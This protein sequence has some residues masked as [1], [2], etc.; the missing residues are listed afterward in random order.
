MLPTFVEVDV[1]DQGKQTL[2]NSLKRF[3][4]SGNVVPSQQNLI[5]KIP[6]ATATNPGV[7]LPIP[8]EGPQDAHTELHSITGAQGLNLFGMGTISSVGAVVTG[9]GT[10]FLSQVAVGD[11]ILE[12]AG[13]SKTVLSITSDTVLNTTANFAPALSNVNFVV[14][15][16]I[17]ADVRDRMTVTIHDV[18]YN[19]LLM[20][21]PVPCNH[22]FGDN[23]KPSMLCERIFLQKNHV[24]RYQFFNNSTSGAGSMG[25]TMEGRKWQIEA[26]ENYPEVDKLM[27]SF[28]ARETFLSPYWLTLETSPGTTKTTIPAGGNINQF[29]RNT[30]SNWLFLFFAY[31]HG[32]STGAAGETTE[33]FSFELFDKETDTP[34]QRMPATLNT[35]LGTAQNPYRFPTPIIMKPRSQLRV[36]FTNLITDQATDVFMTLGGVALLDAS[37]G[38]ADPAIMNEARR[39]YDATSPELIQVAGD[40]NS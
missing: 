11:T 14:T 20:N 37:T 27:K 24:L 3:V 26:S 32:I 22:I 33:M 28:V 30:G 15:T 34:L 12:P 1:P 5:T 2:I 10:K 23:Q 8:L 36:N 40:V 6:A 19:R 35:G 9:V 29:L 21:A 31:G 38:I 39:I 4:L 25:F 16:P 7:S 18:S 17:V 13:Q